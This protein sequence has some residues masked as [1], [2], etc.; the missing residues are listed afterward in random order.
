MATPEELRI[1]IS[2]QNDTKKAFNEVNTDL[3]TT[4]STAAKTQKAIMGTSDAMGT[5]GK[6]AG[7]AGIQIQQFVGQVQ[8]GTNPLV[9][10][11][12]QATDLGFV[13]GF[14]LLG[15]VTGIAAAFAGPLIA[16]IMGVKEETKDLAKEVDD[17]AERYDT[18]TAA[19]K[20]Y[21]DLISGRQI[22]N[23]TSELKTL[24]NEQESLLAMMQTPSLSYQKSDLFKEQSD[25][26]IELGK[27]IDDTQ[28]R[29][30]ALKN[31][32]AEKQAKEAIKIA[33]DSAAE[34]L[35]LEDEL[36]AEFTQ[37]LQDR[38]KAEN[39]AKQYQLDLQD[40]M[41]QA[42]LKQQEANQ[43]AYLDMVEASK[44]QLKPLEDSLVNLINGSKDVS[45][46]FRDMA[47]SIIN[48]LIR[49]QIQKSITGPLAGMIAGAGGGGSILGSLGSLLG[50]EGGGYT[51][52]GARSG[53]VDGRGGFPAIL[54]PNETVVDHTQ[55]QSGGVT[56]N[57]TINVTTGVQQTVRTEIASL[58]PQI[59][60]ASKQAVLDARK[61]GGSFGAAFGA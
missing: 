35:R 54:H 2:A 37:R 12:Q 45:T 10:F 18:L 57:Q 24:K 4:S 52:S 3:K 47:S 21:Y 44:K 46:S 58:M 30:D 48:D 34:Q 51:G 61:R 26:L 20:R 11:S 33:K 6:R 28:Q 9:A 43:K 36:T 49:I 16:S 22:Q 27:L 59:A 5:M 19:Q 29:I 25:R 60:A 17:L 42:Y 8:M 40:N 50:F 39:D 38:I 15:A 41:T 53:G 55:G 1:R 23:L 32:L 13:L 14:P 7:Q 31:P 56:I